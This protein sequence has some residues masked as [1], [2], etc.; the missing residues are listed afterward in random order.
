MW[1]WIICQ[2]NT[3]LENITYI[4]GQNIKSSIFNFYYA[5]I[6]LFILVSIITKVLFPCLSVCVSEL[7]Y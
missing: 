6:L 5:Q 1:A 2:H 4:A 3:F 7:F